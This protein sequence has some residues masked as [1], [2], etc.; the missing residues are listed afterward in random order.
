MRSDMSSGPSQGGLDNGRRRVLR[1]GLREGLA[2]DDDVSAR[3]DLSLRR[4]V[5]IT[6]D[7]RREPCGQKSLPAACS[8]LEEGQGLMLTEIPA[9]KT[10]RTAHCSPR[11]QHRV[12]G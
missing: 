1:V 2:F 7:V 4:V 12:F 6:V 10:D 5:I 9:A 11:H 8:R 3:P